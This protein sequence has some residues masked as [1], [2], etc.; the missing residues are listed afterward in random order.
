LILFYIGRCEHRLSLAAARTVGK[1][2]CACALAEHCPDSKN[3][4]LCTAFA[5]SYP[6]ESAMYSQRLSVDGWHKLTNQMPRH[7][8]NSTLKAE[9]YGRLYFARA[10]NYVLS[11]DLSL[12]TNRLHHDIL[13][14][15]E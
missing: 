2:E 4:L 5:P 6:E 9:A 12:W 8:K 14:L 3:H 13:S 15:K 11:R 7:A 1:K 10:H